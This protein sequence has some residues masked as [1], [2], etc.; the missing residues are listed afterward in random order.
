MEG[1]LEYLEKYN[2]KDVNIGSFNKTRLKNIWENKIFLLDIKPEKL[3]IEAVNLL[4]DSL[5]DKVQMNNK[6][7]D[8]EL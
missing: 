5:Y 6:N 3:G 2:I 4:V 1:F 7:V 8:I